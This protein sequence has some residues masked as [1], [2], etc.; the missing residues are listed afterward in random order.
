MEVYYEF[1]RLTPST[2]Y[3]L[4]IATDSNYDFFKCE[5]DA[6]TYTEVNVES[7]TS[8]AKG[9]LYDRYVDSNSQLID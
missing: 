1:R 2:V 7:V 8:D 6:T 4:I 9:K 5:K 3:K